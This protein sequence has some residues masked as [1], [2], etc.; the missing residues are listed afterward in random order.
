MIG[1]EGLM[2]SKYGEA[3]HTLQDSWST[4]ACRGFP[5]PAP[6]SVAILLTPRLIRQ[7][8]AVRIRMVPR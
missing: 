5:S 1:K 6:A 2:L 7:D 4:P 3:L 8:V